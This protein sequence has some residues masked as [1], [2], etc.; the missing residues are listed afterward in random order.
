MA[1]E[2]VSR[3]SVFF[4]VHWKGYMGV[5]TG[6][7]GSFQNACGKSNRF[8]TPAFNMGIGA[9]IPIVWMFSGLEVANGADM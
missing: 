8:P 4:S 2:I 9:F 7:D 5:G 1:E 6:N 3:D